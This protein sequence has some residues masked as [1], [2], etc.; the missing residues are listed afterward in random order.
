[1]NIQA[2]WFPGHMAKTLR[3][4][5]EQVKLVDVVV[6]LVD[7]RLPL[8]SRNP[9]LKKFCQNKK[10]IVLLNK[11]DLADTAISQAWLQ[12]Y[13]AAQQAALLFSCKEKSGLNKLEKMIL[14]LTADILAQAQARGRE[15]RPIR[16]MVMGVPNC[17]KSTF[18]NT[19][20]GR[21]SAN[22][23]NRPGVTRA[24]KWIKS[25]TNN[26]EWLDTPGLLWPK[27]EFA[28]Q[29]LNLALAGSIP[30]AILDRESIVYEGF[31]LLWERYPEYLAKRY[32]IDTTLEFSPDL[33][34]MAVTNHGCLRAGKKLDYERFAKAFL[35]DF[36]AAV[37]GPI[38]LE[39]P[40]EEMY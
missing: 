1:M 13:A 17:G 14:D 28:K 25:S 24:N 22:T 40:N 23:E 27:I 33:F 38:S 21:K 20:V 5:K 8:S 29:R 34:D 3:L 15:N 12:H 35:N 6:E 36:R 32:K 31:K 16:V 19:L 30:E 39:K 9:E 2:Q 10:H 7:A 37:L 26:I 4:L 18:I 11:S